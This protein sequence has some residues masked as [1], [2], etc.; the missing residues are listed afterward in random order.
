MS[1][2][3]GLNG[4]KPNRK[5]RVAAYA[6]VSVSKDGPV[7][8]L[9]NQIDYYS[10]FI[11]MHEE[12]EFAGV[13]FDDGITGTDANKRDGF[14]DLMKSC[15]A[16]NIDIVLVKSISRFARN[17]V[18]LLKYVRELK[19]L[20]IAV[21]FERE[22]INSMNADGELM[23]T[24]LGSFAQEESRNISDNVKWGI[25]KLFKE[26]KQNG[27][28]E[29]YGYMW[30]GEKYVIIPKEGEV[31]K[32]IFDRYIAG[33]SAYKI[34][35]DLKQEGISFSESTIKYILSN[36]CYTGTMILQRFYINDLHKRKT[37]KGELNK[38]AVSDMYEP[39][40][41]NDDFELVQ[42]IRNRRANTPN[43]NYRKTMFSGLTKCGCC[44]FGVSR[45]TT[46]Y[47]KV[48]KCNNKERNKACDLRTIHEDKLFA[49][50][51]KHVNNNHTDIFERDENLKRINIHDDKV[52]FVL[53][54]KTKI[55]K[56]GEKHGT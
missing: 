44:G 24:L 4:I 30:N 22:G 54:G 37:N 3:Q 50:Y 48:W 13:F 25:R 9:K 8:S 34:C 14:K 17:T 11:Y 41:S 15:R 29:P 2:L 31:I 52:E 18:D 51:Q 12:W 27:Y 28:K 38:Y 6:R 40:V 32:R 10:N 42:S 55:A 43:K 53:N 47:N 5:T 49:L 1:A 39:L 21:I 19:E 36:P 35:K 23:L 7:Q 45:R 33:D 20:G 26:G 16:G 46:K 56:R